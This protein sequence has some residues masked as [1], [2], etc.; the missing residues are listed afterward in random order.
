MGE[1]A[2][3]AVMPITRE[4]W[5]KTFAAWGEQGIERIN[6]LMQP[7]AEIAASSPECD[8]LEILG[9]SDSRSS[10][11]DIIVFYADCANGKRFYV[12]EGDVL[13]K[14]EVVTQDEKAT[15]LDDQQLIEIS[16][17]AVKARLNRPCSFLSAMVYR[18]VVGRSV[19]TVNCC[20]ANDA[21]AKM[22]FAAKCYF[23]ALSLTEVE[24]HPV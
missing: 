5:P 17:E 24:I 14:R 20:T 6:A 15:W 21:G 13:A 23:D 19:V 18:A 22:T 11:P 8:K 7:A 16:Q 1:I 4:Q 9:L 12:T 2:D 10:P 3:G